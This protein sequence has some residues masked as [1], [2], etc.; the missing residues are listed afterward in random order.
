MLPAHITVA[1]YDKGGTEISSE[2]LEV[3]EARTPGQS[4]SDQG[5]GIPFERGLMQGRRT[6][7]RVPPTGDLAFLKFLQ[8]SE[9][10]WQAGGGVRTTKKLGRAETHGLN[11]RQALGH[12]F[13][14]FP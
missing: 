13:Q 7:A 2:Q 3:N 9:R 12:L 4:Y 14:M 1:Y 10:L 5:L 11:R 8:K 6:L